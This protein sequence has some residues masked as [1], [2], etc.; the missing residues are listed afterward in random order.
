MGSGS[1]TTLAEAAAV[2]QTG[3]VWL[4]RGGRPA[5]RA[6]RLFTNSP[7]NHVA[8][9]VVI[10]D[11]PPLLW[12]AELGSALPDV[13]TGAHQRGAQLHR[14]EDAVGTW[15]H[16]YGQRAWVRQLDIA[17]TAEMENRLLS[18]IDE[19]SGRSF[20]KSASLV[21]RWLLGRFRRPVTLEDIYCA[22]L[23][24]VSFERM[25]LLP[26]ARPP[27]WY[28]P[29]RFWSGDQLPLVGATLSAEIEVTDIP[30]PPHAG[31]R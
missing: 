2:S 15:S 4:F 29:G 19:Y 8:L 18:T 1:T 28:D 7:V 26:S 5:D 6:I 22:E 16:R 25:G 12:H 14:L 24:A 20:P 3:D 13:W 21:S 17:P 11:L 27:N 31:R 30:R 9:A 10:D 23:V